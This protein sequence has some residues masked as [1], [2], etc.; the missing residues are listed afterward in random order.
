M[1]GTSCNCFCL[2]LWQCIRRQICVAVSGS[3]STTHLGL[4]LLALCA[5]PLVPPVISRGAP[6]QATWETSVNEVQNYGREMAGQ[7]CLRFRLPR[8]SQGSFTCRKSATWDRRLY[9]PSEGRHAVDLP[10]KSDGFGR[11]RIR[12]FGVPEASMLTTR[13]RIYVQHT[14]GGCVVNICYFAV[15]MWHCLNT[16]GVLSFKRR[17]ME[18]I[19]FSTYCMKLNGLLNVTLINCD[20][21]FY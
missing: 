4:K 18:L 6:R 13:A 8:I 15:K 17:K 10:E 12:D 16:F 3:T 2:A 11:V 20:R 5:P 14:G 1:K 9:F 7:F 19:P 21:T